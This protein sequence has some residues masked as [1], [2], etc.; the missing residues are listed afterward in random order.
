MRILL[1]EDDDRV[2]QYLKENLVRDNHS[3]SLVRSLTELQAFV[4]D[5]P[6]APDLFILDR[7]LGN[8]DTRGMLKRIKQRFAGAGIIFLSA[9]NSPAEKAALL[10]EGADDYLGKPFSLIELEARVR[11]LLRRRTQGAPRPAAGIYITVG[12][13]VI[14]LKTRNVTSNGK[15]LELTPKEFSL[16]VNFCEHKGRVFTKFQLLDIIWETN[17]DIESNVIEVNIMNLR[18]KLDA[19]GSALKIQS[20]RNVGY[21]LEA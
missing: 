9:L 10:D 13:T 15:R 8:D 18:K 17:L 2:S 20:K 14:D 16:F 5:A 6:E 4:E 7:L 11:A 21:W 19:C 3:V 1:V 12:D